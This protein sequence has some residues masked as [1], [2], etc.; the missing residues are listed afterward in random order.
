MSSSSSESEM[1]ETPQPLEIIKPSV[2]SNKK[3]ESSHGKRVSRLVEQYKHFQRAK[4]E[5]K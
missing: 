5:P 4:G 3:I 1:L 2:M